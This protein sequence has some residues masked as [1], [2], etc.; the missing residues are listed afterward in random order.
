MKS[1]SN[2]VKSTLAKRQRKKKSSARK[3]NPA[4]LPT[5]ET[6]DPWPAVLTAWEPWASQER[7]S[8]HNTSK[9]G[10]MWRHISN[11]RRCVEVIDGSG[12][13]IARLEDGEPDVLIA[14]A[15]LM[16]AAPEMFQVLTRTL[17]LVLTPLPK[18]VPEDTDPQELDS[19]LWEWFEAASAAVFLPGPGGPRWSV[20]D[21]VRVR[22]GY[23]RDIYGGE[24]WPSGRTLSPEEMAALPSYRPGDTWREDAERNYGKHSTG[25]SQGG[26]SS[27]SPGGSAS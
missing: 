21:V 11:D 27:S 5:R 12:R 23:R 6:D 4:E 24:E 17:E 20:E 22:H 7:A 19:L 25:E 8:A 15:M 26:A 1:K 13:V 14:R 2:P 9:E 3:S 18:G 10:W 16:T